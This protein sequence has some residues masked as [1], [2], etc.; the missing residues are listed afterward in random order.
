MICPQCGD[1]FT[2]LSHERGARNRRFC[3][4]A[5]RFRAGRARAKE[6]VV[7]HPAEVYTW[8]SVPAQPDGDTW[9]LGRTFDK[10]NIRCTLDHC[11]WPAGAVV[12]NGQGRLWRVSYDQGK[13]Y[14]DPVDH[15]GRAIWG[16]NVW[17]QHRA[18]QP[19]NAVLEGE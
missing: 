2:P 1:R 19:K 5:C 14:L 13:Q 7:G 10:A 9:P 6:A 16:M 3:S 12:S 15:D 4:D 11:G 18:T 8:V 17:W